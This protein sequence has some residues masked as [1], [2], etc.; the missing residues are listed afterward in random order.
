MTTKWSA[1][2]IRARLAAWYTVVLSLMLVVYAAATFIAVRH[3]FVE[4]LDD[5]LR[6]DFEAAEARLARTP[7]GRIAWTG[8]RHA[9]PD[10]DE[11]RAQEA[12][13][14]A[15]E[16]IYRSELATALPPATLT[17]ATIRARYESVT[18]SGERWRMLSRTADIGGRPIVLR[19]SRSEERLRRQLAEILVVL[20][21]GVRSARLIASRRTPDG[22]PQIACT[23]GC[24]SRIPTTSLAGWRVSSMRRSSAWSRLSISSVASRRM[25]RTSFVLRWR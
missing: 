6:D 5:Q 10:A 7:D 22:L 21:R 25:P 4:Q 17:A 19:V 23:S 11:D 24:R 20:T 14:T 8:D 12:W 3:E 1:L 13:S 16:P 9:D 18:A 2:S 15:G